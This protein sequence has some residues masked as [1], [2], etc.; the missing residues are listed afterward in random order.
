MAKNNRI[1]VTKEFTLDMAHALDH[2]DGKCRHIHG[3]TFQ[4]SITV[5]GH[6]E[7]GTDNPKSGMVMDFSILKN[8]IQKEIITTFDH[9]LVIHKDS[10]YKII[11]SEISHERII[12][13]PYSPTCENILLDFVNRVSPLLP[14]YIKLHS[15]KLRETPTSYAEWY[16]NDQLQTAAVPGVMDQY[17]N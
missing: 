3:H 13:V 9:S 5:I 15:M 16:A 2:Y 11:A 10:P 1:R 17:S 12:P 8:I 4:L 7:A 6:P 14:E